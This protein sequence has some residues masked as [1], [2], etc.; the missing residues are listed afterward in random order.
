[1]VDPEVIKAVKLAAIEEATSSSVILEKA[2]S[3]WLER[4]KSKKT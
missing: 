2:A 3:E 4:R 1:M